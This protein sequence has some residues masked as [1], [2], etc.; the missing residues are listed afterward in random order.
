[1]SLATKFPEEAP[2][3]VTPTSVP[4]PNQSPISPPTDLP[5]SSSS[6]SFSKSTNATISAAGEQE[7]S[8]VNLST[9]DSKSPN[10]ALIVIGSCAMVGLAA[11]AVTR[12]KSRNEDSPL[13]GTLVKEGNSEI[14]SIKTSDNVISTNNSLDSDLMH[15]I[16]M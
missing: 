11:F 10:I 3:P 7:N 8:S 14:S 16:E 5:V 15:N 6:P 2:T 4:A 12:L 1:M 13:Y 9:A